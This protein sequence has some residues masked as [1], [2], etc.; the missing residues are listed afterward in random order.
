M[1]KD[2]RDLVSR[3][4]PARPL[5]QVVE[6]E[7][8]IQVLFQNMGQLGGFD[9]V[10][11]GTG[12][13]FLAHHDPER[14]GCVVLDLNLPDCTG[15][16]LVRYLAKQPSPPP[17]VFMSGMAKISEAVNA[18]KLGSIDFVEKPFDL[19]QMLETLHRAIEVDA[20]R[21][22][23]T[24]THAEVQRRF[25]RLT[26]REHQVM[27]LIVAGAA[28]KE[29]AAALGVSPKTVEMHRANVMRKMQANS[30]AELVRM[31]VTQLQTA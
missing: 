19:C 7:E 22:A 26:P 31:S 29:V 20:S 13:D 23:S 21:R 8:S 1:S 17:V 12:T 11:Y 25:A 10:C 28:N 16:D 3:G 4:G 2:A 24:A 30:L 18:L 27:D 15:L 5:V 9:V 6:D 14:P